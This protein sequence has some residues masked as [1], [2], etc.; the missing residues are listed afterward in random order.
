M[1]TQHKRKPQD[2]SRNKVNSS[3]RAPIEEPNKTT[4]IPYDQNSGRHM[5]GLDE[6]GAW[7]ISE[8]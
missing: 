7:A 8:P 4:D 1:A 2:V 6:K 5:S 3:E